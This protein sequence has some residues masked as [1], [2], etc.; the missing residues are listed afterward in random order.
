LR[1]LSEALSLAVID[2]PISGDEVRANSTTQIDH[3]RDRPTKSPTRFTTDARETLH[4]VSLA[5]R[6]LRSTTIL[7]AY[8]TS[9]P[10]VPVATA[11]LFLANTTGGKHA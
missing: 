4:T 10:D 9:A 2:D 8:F 7:E 1:Q 11:I 6:D 3:N 5:L